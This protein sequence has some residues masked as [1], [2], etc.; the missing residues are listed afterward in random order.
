MHQR[1]KRFLQRLFLSLLVFVSCLVALPYGVQYSL[2]KALTDAGSKQV[3]ID[4]VDFNLF[5]GELAIKKLR[6]HRLQKATLDVSLIKIDLDWLALF[7]KRLL[8]SSLSLEDSSLTI[9][10]P[11]KKTLFIA[12]IQIPLAT[13]D[14]EDKQN[15]PS[16]T[17]GIG[18]GK[19]H[20]INTVIN[21]HS[22]ELDEKL[23]IE[24]F[25]LD[26]AFSWESDHASDSTFKIQL[27]QS[28]VSGKLGVSV[29]ADKPSIKGQLNIKKLPLNRFHTLV[30]EQLTEL[31]GNLS[32][33]IQFSASYG[34]DTLNYQQTGSITLNTATIGVAQLKTNIATIN[35]TGSN[36]YSKTQDE[37]SITSKGSLAV[38]QV[39]I[40]DQHSTLE[41]ASIENLRIN[42]LNI[43]HLDNIQIGSL[44]AAGLIIAK[45]QSTKP[46]VQTKKILLNK[47]QLH[48]LSR[49]DINSINLELVLAQVDIDK[50]NQI[51]LLNKLQESLNTASSKTTEPSIT[52]DNNQTTSQFRLGSLTI[53]GD[54]HFQLSK[55]NE[56]G[57]ITKDIQLLEFRL[58]ELNSA[59]PDK[60]T[61]VA[62]LA[63]IDKFSNLSTKGHVF[64][65]S[66]K[67]NI[68]IKTTLTAF[69]LQHFSPL[70]R[71]LL[72]YKIQNGQLNANLNIVVN[73]NILDGKTEV[74]INQLVLE[75]ANDDKVAKMAQQLSMSLDSALSL[76]RDKN[77]DI[78]LNIPI[79]GDLS[80]PSF[81]I[82][83][84][85]NTAL[86]NAIQGS[87][88]SFL[89]YA[90]QPY[91]LIYMAAEK[92]HDMA[93][94][95]KLDALAFGAGNSELS[96]DAITYLQRIGELMQK[97]P[98][99]RVRVCGVST[100]TDSTALQIF[101]NNKTTKEKLSL[102]Q[103][104]QE[105]DQQLINLANNRVDT[106]KSHLI[107]N[108]SIKA[109][110][111][112][113]CA[114]KVENDQP[115]RNAAMPR[116]EL[117]I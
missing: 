36:T 74:E 33:D 80:S 111:L 18:L 20:L 72:G 38:D 64:P 107:L 100:S 61:P 42:L 44:E 47:I 62:L 28:T 87:V 69:E 98:N 91:G 13:E 57:T 93:T 114:P 79:S 70:I 50:Q 37:H 90:L 104:A 109:I 4:D 105:L 84:V 22:T 25:L 31:N 58:G 85:I 78:K 108:Y 67:S 54:S 66:E 99:L 29:F 97:R 53:T 73:N 101:S 21:Y 88:K 94:T 26:E 24:N 75:P 32:A 103:Q 81:N 6:A 12:G 40:N 3:F 76:L 35:W 110:R 55:S 96:T 92:A 41:L 60:P 39:F 49:V 7:R 112:F 113:T 34:K 89:K 77:D 52:N 30:K 19:L 68:N 48:E 65:F 46:L 8:I 10:Q 15:T 86:V 45:D 63:T 95:I 5:T 102:E 115:A 82:N 56:H 43:K 117:S 1:Q 51:P 59:M 106:V 27:N 11:D 83:Q 14:N 2:T 116:V 16:A 23:V 17:W 9:E 71:E